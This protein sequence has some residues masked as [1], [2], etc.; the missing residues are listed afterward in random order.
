L[1]SRCILSRLTK[2]L[3]LLIASHQRHLCVLAVSFPDSTSIVKR[4][5]PP[6]QVKALMKVK[7]KS[8]ISDYHLT[9]VYKVAAHV[10]VVGRHFLHFPT[11][12]ADSCWVLSISGLS[13][14][15]CY[16]LAEAFPTCRH[17]ISV[18]CSCSSLPSEVNTL[19]SKWVPMI[20]LYVVVLAT[21][22]QKKS[23]SMI[24]VCV[25]HHTSMLSHGP[26]ASW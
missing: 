17:T 14:H 21:S 24:V 6:L 23:K 26:S 18:A 22:Q 1:L 2:V 5:I 19:Q 8:L 25:Q 12:A 4:T 13:C 16:A 9:S 7:I 10:T 15:D 20:C 11:Q 3:L